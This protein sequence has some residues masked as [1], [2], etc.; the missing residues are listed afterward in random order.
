MKKLNCDEARQISIVDYLAQCGINPQYSKGV[1]HWYLSPIR[2]ENSASFK[3]NTKLNAWFDHGIGE[4][5]N[6]I[7][8]GIRLHQCTVE[9]LLT[10]LSYGDRSLP[11]HQPITA[12]EQ[13][14]AEPENKIVIHEARELHNLTLVSYLHSREIDYYH[15]K[16]YCKEVLFSVNGQRHLALGFEN[17]SGGYELRSAAIKLSSSPKD[18]T[19]IDR[20]FDTLYVT[21][22]F[23]DFL[24]L[25][26]FN[27][28]DMPGNFLVLNSLSFVSAS[29]DVLQTHKA[30]ELYLDHDKAAIKAVATIKENVLNVH[31]ASHFYSGHKDLNAYLKHEHQQQQTKG[32]HL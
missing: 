19:F 16:K 13:I 6:F 1:N 25:L 11:F 15:T 3:V 17:R 24:S 8:L 10:K 27:R 4:G 22:G 7:D 18:L 26:T 12:A 14:P 29:L 20:G 28:R 30:V 9:E 32:L 23:M 5:G 21:E 31:D 2:E